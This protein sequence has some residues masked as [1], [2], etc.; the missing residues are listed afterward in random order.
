[1][2]TTLDAGNKGVVFYGSTSVKIY[3]TEEHY[4]RGDSDYI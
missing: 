3:L 2:A 4:P 1:M